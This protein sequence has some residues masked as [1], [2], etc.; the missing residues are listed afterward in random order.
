MGENSLAKGPHLCSAPKEPKG[1]FNFGEEGLSERGGL[2]KRIFQIGT[3]EKVG[4]AAKE[5]KRKR[6]DFGFEDLR[7]FSDLPCPE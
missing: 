1:F 3:M 2:E 6:K 5:D 7:A 4:W